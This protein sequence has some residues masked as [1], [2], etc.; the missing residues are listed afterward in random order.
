MKKNLLS[1]IMFGAAMLFACCTP[2]DGGDNNPNPGV[3]PE[4]TITTA[5]ITH[6]SV[7][8]TITPASADTW[9]FSTIYSE[10]ELKLYAQNDALAA[11]S[12]EITYYL[13]VVKAY[14]DTLSEEDEK[15]D[16]TTFGFDSIVQG[17]QTMTAN[18]LQPETAYVI[19]VV[20][21][22]GNGI[23]SEKATTAKF[24]STARPQGKTITF[25]PLAASLECYGNIYYVDTNNQVLSLYATTDSGNNA[26]IKAEFF[27]TMEDHYGV[28][29]YVVDGEF[30]GDA[31]TFWPGSTDEDGYLYPTS[32]AESDAK[33]NILSY[34]CI[35]D[36]PLSIAKNENG[37]YTVN[38]ELLGENGNTYKVNYTYT[39]NEDNYFDYCS[40][41][42]LL[43]KT[44][45]NHAIKVANPTSKKMLKACSLGAKDIRR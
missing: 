29:S 1:M 22:D 15:K 37:S 33:G 4:F 18:Y 10:K 16:L 32:Y 36:G 41:A 11:A 43:S 35:I 8:A 20:E 38:A 21:V 2:N 26:T 28:G 12:V 40:S 19:I 34:E 42:A 9:W 27:S 13:D 25:Q 39:L 30:V 31:G 44:G 6:K 23:V 14:N 24:T 5:N 7:Q 3:T 17:T 45:K